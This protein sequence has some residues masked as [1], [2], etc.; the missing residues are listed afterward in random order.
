MARACVT[1]R[2]GTALALVGGSR[3]GELLHRGEALLRRLDVTGLD[4]RLHLLQGR[5]PLTDIFPLRLTA[6]QCADCHEIAPSKFV[7]YSAPLGMSS[8]PDSEEIAPRGLRESYERSSISRPTDGRQ[9]NDDPSANA[10]LEV[11]ET[12][13]LG[14]I[15]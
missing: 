12:S 5:P 11:F 7:Q 2:I 3:R 13:T 9:N 15:C 8:G 4:C 6:A 14:G 10:R 1:F